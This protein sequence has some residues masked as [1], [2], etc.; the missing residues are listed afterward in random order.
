[1]S[2][3]ELLE[4]AIDDKIKDIQLGMVAK[5]ESFDPITMRAD[6]DPLLKIKNDLGESEDLPILSD[7]PVRFYYGGG[8]LIK[9]AYENGDLVWLAFSTHD[10]ENSLQEYK[11]NASDKKFEIHNACV[12]GGIVKDNF[13]FPPLVLTQIQKDGMVLANKKG[14]SLRIDDIGIFASNGITEFNILTHVHPTAAP[15]PPSPPTPGS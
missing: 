6:I 3:S 2:F 15:G 1:M 8:Y 13:V 12:M 11:R 14:I 4:K 10:L 9:P 7:L 5:I